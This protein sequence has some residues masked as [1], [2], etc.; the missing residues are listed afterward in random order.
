MNNSVLYNILLI[1]ICTHLLGIPPIAKSMKLANVEFCRNFCYKL[2]RLV[3]VGKD[4]HHNR[5]RGI[6][7]QIS[8]NTVNQSID[9]IK[10]FN[11]TSP[12]DFCQSMQNEMQEKILLESGLK[13]S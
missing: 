4:V 3:L 6:Y 9:I 5:V 7:M 10:S 11:Y 13:G 12:V 1:A 2:K 8:R